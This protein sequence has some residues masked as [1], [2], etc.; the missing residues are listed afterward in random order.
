MFIKFFYFKKSD[1]YS[2]ISGIR[3]CQENLI[4]SHQ[5]LFYCIW[6]INISVASYKT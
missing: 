6:E 2:T 5:D 4:F 3:T 1:A